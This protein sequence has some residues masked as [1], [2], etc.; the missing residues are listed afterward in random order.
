MSSVLIGIDPGVKTGVG[1]INGNQRI[2]EAMPI[3]QAMQSIVNLVNKK[4]DI[5]I[6]I[7]DARLRKWFGQNS[8][9]KKQGAGSVKRDCKIWEDFL[10]DLKKSSQQ[11]ITF[12]MIHPVKGATKINAKMFRQITGIQQRTNEHGRDA[13]MLIQGYKTK[14]PKTKVIRSNNNRVTSTLS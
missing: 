5:H 13:Y 12:E 14:T 9:A 7:E 2:A 6:R 3:H 11:S 8:A 10:T 4:K 1:I